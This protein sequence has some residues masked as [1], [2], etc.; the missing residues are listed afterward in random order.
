[1][2]IYSYQLNTKPPQGR[3]TLITAH[4]QRVKHFEKHT[5]N[6]TCTKVEKKKKAAKDIATRFADH[7]INK[8]TKVCGNPTERQGRY[9]LIGPG[10]THIYHK[11][12]A[13]GATYYSSSSPTKISHEK[14]GTFLGVEA[15]V[16]INQDSMVIEG[17]GLNEIVTKALKS[18]LALHSEGESNVIR[19]RN[20]HTMVLLQ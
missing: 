9:F 7:Y 12:Y 8:R 18:Q 15:K 3:V 20:M 19:L 2:R 11:A 4:S 17:K 6:S 13:K 1:M 14:I 16:K 5:T 10:R